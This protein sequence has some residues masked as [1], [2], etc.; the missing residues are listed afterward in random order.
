MDYTN[1][2]TFKSPAGGVELSDT[3]SSWRKKTNGIV[4]KVDSLDSTAGTLA[5]T[6]SA[7]TTTVAN[8]EVDNNSI[9]LSKVQLLGNNKLLGNTSGSTADVSV[10]SI[11][12]ET[13]GITA[14]DNDTSIPTS[15]AVKH[16]SD[17]KFF[18]GQTVQ[19]NVGRY[20]NYTSYTVEE[21]SLQASGEYTTSTNNIISAENFNR[22]GSTTKRMNAVRVPVD[23]S[24]TPTY[25][26]SLIC[27][28]WNLLGEA[29]HHDSGFWI[30]RK[31]SDNKYEIINDAGYEG[32]NSAVATGRN[33]FF[34]PSPYDHSTGTTPSMLTIRYFIPAVDTSQKTYGLIFGSAVASGDFRLNGANTADNWYPYEVGVSNVTI[35]ELYQV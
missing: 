24:I 6:V 9:L 4:M 22:E 12:D 18:N 11:V 26:N 8:S 31:R 30:G 23:I 29:N 28:E 1:F 19:Q 32:Y 15:A 34:H 13:A 10:V 20:D 5:G 3:L 27:V 33:N 17:N 7:L 21:L 35:K 25:A 16:Y 2:D 14:N